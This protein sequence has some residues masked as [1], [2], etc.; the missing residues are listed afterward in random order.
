MNTTLAIIKPDA[1][2]RNITGAINTVIENAGF[3]IIGQKRIMIS[4][5]DAERFYAAYVDRPFFSS[6]VDSISSAPV[7]VQVLEKDNAVED[8]RE[9]MGST[10]PM[11][12]KEG[13]IRKL[14]GLNIEQNS[15]YGSCHE[16]NAK[17]E[18]AFFFSE[19]EIVP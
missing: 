16:E 10:N 6:L 7:I 19:L 11:D 18:I 13:T 3:K 15:I 2:M 8:F 14:F 1:T 4:K 17:D 9:L 5:T 12:A